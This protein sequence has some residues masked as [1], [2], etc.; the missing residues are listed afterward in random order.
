[1]TT[2]RDFATSQLEIDLIQ[3]TSVLPIFELEGNST[4][5]AVAIPPGYTQHHESITELMAVHDVPKRTQT[6]MRAV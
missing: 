3:E 2:G 1:M 6:E 5:A 4:V